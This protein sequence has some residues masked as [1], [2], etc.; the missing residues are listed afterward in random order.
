MGIFLPDRC[1]AYRIC[2][3]Y[4]CTALKAEPHTLLYENKTE[5][6]EGKATASAP[7]RGFLL[8]DQPGT[9]RRFLVKPQRKITPIKFY[10]RALNPPHDIDESFPPQNW[11]ET[12]AATNGAN[13]KARTSTIDQY[14]RPRGGANRD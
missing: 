6:S 12:G 14:Q 11:H 4:H 3:F 1:V 2:G 8:G 10:N 9:R 7:E 5:S 13:I